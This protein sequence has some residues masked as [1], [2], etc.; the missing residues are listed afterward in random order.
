M[1]IVG[2]VEIDDYCQKIL[3]LRWPDVP[4][5]KDIREVDGSDVLKKCGPIDL[6]SG[7]FPCQDISQ[8]GKGK[9]LEGERSGLW[10]EYHRL[11]REI[12]PRYCLV[13]NVSALLYRGLGTVLGDLAS[14]GF[15]AAWRMFSSREMGYPDERERVFIVAYHERKRGL[16]LFKKEVQKFKGMERFKDVRRVEDFFK[17]PDT[18][19]PLI[20]GN[21]DG[22]ADVMERLHLL[23]NGQNAEV[24][25][26]IGKRIMEYQSNSEAGEKKGGV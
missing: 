26:W 25:E 16:S 15:D 3:K 11:I 2:Q 6:I 4:K 24:V 22:V 20:R 1:E 7:G 10:R 13:E 9:G 21:R 12:R 5:W 19:K 8:H 14:C 17:L 23:G 18:P